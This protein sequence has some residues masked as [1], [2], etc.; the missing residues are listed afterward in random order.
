MLSWLRRSFAAKLLA[1]GLSLALVV[2]GGVSGYLLVSRNGQ[3]RVGALSN[4]DNRV[5]TMRA[6]LQ[7]FVGEQSF[8]T[9][10]ALAGQLPLGITLSGGAPGVTVPTLFSQSPP[11][12]LSGETLIIADRS[13]MA[14]YTR[15]AA[16]LHD[17][18]AVHYAQSKALMA[19]LAGSECPVTHEPGAC[20]VELLGGRTPVYSVAVPVTV[21]GEAV[22]VVAYVAP[23]GVQLNR[24]SALFQFPTAFIPAGS[25]GTEIRQRGATNVTSA[26]PSDVLRS[27]GQH[28]DP[29]HATYVAP[30]GAVNAGRVVAGSYAAVASPDGRT[31]GYIGIEVPLSI[32]VGDQQTDELT[33][34]VITLFALL[35]VAILVIL[36]VEVFVRRPIHRLERGVARIADGDYTSAVDVR[37]RDELGRLAISVNRMRDNIRAYTTEIQ[38]ARAR[39]DSAVERVSGVSRALTTTTGGMEALHAEVVRTAADIAGEGAVAAL[40]V[41][42]A[43]VLVVKAVHPESSPLTD[44]SRWKTARQVLRGTPVRESVTGLGSLLAVPMF[45]QDRVVGALAVASPDHAAAAAEDEQRVLA[46]L[47]NNA[48]IAMENAR[49][50]EQERD[51]VR[52]LRQ[53]DAM[54]TDFLSTVQHELRTPL[55]AILGLS[56]LIDMCWGMWDDGP[57]LE[58]VRDIQ[59]AARNLYDIVE[60]IIDFSAV[61]GETIDI[62]PTGLRLFDAVEQGIVAVGERYKGGLPIPVD[63]DVS[64]DLV[65][66]ADPARFEQ[67]VRALVDNAVKFS[68]GKGRVMV[69]GSRDEASGGV[70]I[71]VIDHGIG[72]SE[73]DLPRIFDRFYQV[74]NTATRR[75]GGTGMGLA[76]VKRLVQV[77][78]ARVSVETTLGAGTRMILV[79]PST[80]AGQAEAPAG[81]DAA[82]EAVTALVEAPQEGERPAVPVQ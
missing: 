65:I 51:T 13:R 38:G 52:R 25:M 7:R 5:L 36:F 64:H 30:A 55:T 35:I 60:T 1:A 28:Q 19:A 48:A 21:A 75:Y 12:D 14:L 57:K 31:A 6:A 41:E 49:L 78:G 66:H 17:S 77:H 3:T 42:E 11:V 45:Y 16:D 47:A 61:D 20:G 44:L 37:S 82:P 15:P 22:G 80:S 58:A 43:G 46:V 72:I 34:V 74:D 10:R 70:R 4:S 54:K 9:A 24:F 79:W 67:V 63:V 59:V 23:L 26:T 69:R 32:F 8:A 29:A 2:V 18:G 53:L 68:D 81:D 50:F 56:D 27:I 71:E 62:S 39:L 76:L 40:A 33:V 73:D